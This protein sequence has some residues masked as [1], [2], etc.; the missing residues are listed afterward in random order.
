[1]GVLACRGFSGGL[2]SATIGGTLSWVRSEEPVPVPRRGPVG[3]DGWSRGTMEPGT[4]R[5]RYGSFQGEGVGR[6]S[7]S[8]ADVEPKLCGIELSFGQIE[9]AP[10]VAE[11]RVRHTSRRPLYARERAAVSRCDSGN[12][13][14]RTDDSQVVDRMTTRELYAASTEKDSWLTLDRNCRAQ[15]SSYNFPM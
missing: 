1:M 8:L 15:L 11:W 14:G 5:Y 13:N 4:A 6:N 7:P 10:G 2:N 3:F 12:P 9:A